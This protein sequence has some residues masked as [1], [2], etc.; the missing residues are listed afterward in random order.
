MALLRQYAV[1]SYI[2]THGSAC[3]VEYMRQ[4][5]VR[6]FSDRNQVEVANWLVAS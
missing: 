5:R 2:A 1:G 3:M 4:F 6:D